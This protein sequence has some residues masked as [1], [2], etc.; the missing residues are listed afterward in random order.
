MNSRT[1]IL[2]QNI[3]PLKHQIHVLGLGLILL[4]KSYFSLFKFKIPTRQVLEQIVAIGFNTLPMVILIT[5]LSLAVFNQLAKPG[6]ILSRTKLSIVAEH[7][8]NSHL[9]PVRE[10]VEPSGH[11]F[12]SWVQVCFLDFLLNC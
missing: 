9:G 10:T 5:S 12:A 2:P 11:I 3:P 4:L 6:V 7:A 1:T 8:A